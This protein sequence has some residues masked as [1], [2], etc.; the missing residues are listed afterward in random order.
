MNPIALYFASGESLCLGA[1]LLLRMMAILPF[2]RSR[3]RLRSRNLAAWLALA[4]IV[5]ACPPFV[6]VV[7]AIFLAVFALWLI[8]S[9]QA[10]SGQTWTRV[11][12]S[13]TAVLLL[14]PLSLPT[15]EL[16]HH[17]MPVMT[18]AP[19]D[20]LVIIGDS[21]SSGID[22]RVPAWPVVFQQMIGVPVKNLSLPGA[23]AIAALTMAEKI[24]PE[25]RV[26]LIEIGG[27]DLLTGVPSN[28]FGYAFDAFCRKWSRQDAQW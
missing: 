9:N 2:L 26:V 12:L 3:W 1:V 14:L 7:D 6:W 17:T 10:A 27:N 22:S 16:S 8:A 19:S 24:T 18:G 20:H 5:M 11:R 21:I 15:V 13:A 28:E 23:Q 4:M 25:D